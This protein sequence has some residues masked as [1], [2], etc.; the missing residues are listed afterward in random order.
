MR[1][2]M[3]YSTMIPNHISKLTPYE[4]GKPIEEVQRELGIKRVIKLASNENTLGPSPKAIEAIRKYANKVNYYPEGSAY[5]LREK[6][7]SKLSIEMDNIVIGNGTTELVELIAKAVLDEKDH[8]VISKQ[9]FIMYKIA[10]QILNRKYTDISLRNYQYDLADMEKA[11]QENT[12][13]IFIANPNNPTGTY[14]PKRELDNFIKHLPN[15][16]ILVL[17]EAYYEYVC[18]KDYPNGI[19]YF[20]KGYPVIILRTFSKVYGLAGMRVGYAIADKEI[21]NSINKVRSPFNTSSISQIAATAALEDEEHVQKSVELNLKERDFLYKELKKLGFAVLES[22]ANFIWFE[23]IIPQ[24]E[25]YEFLLRKG[26]II[27]PLKAFGFD[28]AFRVTVSTHNENLL[29][30]EKLAEIIKKYK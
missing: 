2:V 27:R 21:I 1:R 3:K 16:V 18:K 30:V 26:I 12:K 5:Y 19:D 4:P 29:L 17:D 15:H 23:S 10:L 25:L 20:K 24:K 8:S 6:I 28:N 9:T 22:A 7:A 13:L 14:V 11:I